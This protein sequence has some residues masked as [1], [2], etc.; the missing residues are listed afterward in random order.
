MA[1][2]FSSEESD[3]NDQSLS[4]HSVSSS[5]IYWTVGGFALVSLAGIILNQL[6]ASKLGVT[7]L[8]RYNSFLAV[9]IVGGQMGSAG[10]HGSVLYHTPKFRSESRPTGQVLVGALTATTVTSLLSTALI[11]GIGEVLLRAAGN[12]YYLRG[13]HAIALGLFLYPLNKVL[14]SH[15]N[16]L[17]RIRSFSILFASRFVLL[18]FFAWGASRFFD[19]DQHLLWTITLTEV[20]M[21]LALLFAARQEFIKNPKWEALNENVRAHFRFGIRGLIGGMLLD[22]NTRVD[23]LLLGVIAG[24]ESVGIYSIG[25]LFA[26]GLY[27]LTMVPR[28][29]YD[30]VVTHLIVEERH[31]ELKDV[32][33]EAKR[34]T[35]FLIIPIVA[36]A[37]VCYP[38]VVGVLFGEDLAMDSWKVFGIL[39]VGLVLSAG[40]VPFT[41]LLQQAGKPTRQSALLGAITGINIVLNLAL[42]PLFGMVGA[43]L[44][45]AIAQVSLIFFLRGLARSVIGYRL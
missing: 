43:A 25:S 33:Q 13:L 40:Y 19:G 15:I 32:V 42:I 3:E 12:D 21:F 4:D 28:Y 8:G 5:G 20:V 30:P 37:N 17:R 41:N 11:L 34:K 22:L 7:S 9:I 38:F 36:I 18:A 23:I 29:S 35:Y 24:S 31:T 1:F 14:L 39:S 26:E 16:G 10:I 6:I 2:S 27:Q 44:A 45:T